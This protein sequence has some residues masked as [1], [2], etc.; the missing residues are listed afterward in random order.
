MKVQYFP[1]SDMLAIQLSQAPATGGGEDVDEGV[2]FSYDEQ[3]RLVLIEIYDASQQVD[4]TDIKSNPT[5]IVDDSNSPTSIY[6]IRLLAE[7]WGM[8][9]RAL[10]QTIGIMR[11]A[12]VEVGHSQGN[13]TTIVLSEEDVEAIK[14]WRQEHPRGRPVAKTAEPV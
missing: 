14:K 6:T 13:T 4:L 2:T 7:Q 5:L 12:G 10:Q 8:S 9:P 3:D 11:K 1:T